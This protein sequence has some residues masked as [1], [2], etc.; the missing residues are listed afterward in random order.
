[1]RIRLTLQSCSNQP[2][3]PLCELFS[4]SLGVGRVLEE[5]KTYVVFPVFKPESQNYCPVVLIMV[6]SKG[7]VIDTTLNMVFRGVI[8]RSCQANLIKA[9]KLFTKAIDKGSY[10][11]HLTRLLKGL[12]SDKSFRDSGKVSQL[13]IRESFVAW[14]LHCLCSS[15]S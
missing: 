3:G 12:R 13:R 4:L 2:A 11:C 6:V 15:T 14:L 5:W 7:T 1:M 9:M 10:G 8:C